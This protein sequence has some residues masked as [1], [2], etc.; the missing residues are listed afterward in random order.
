MYL[1]YIFVVFCVVFCCCFFVFFALF[2]GCV[3][4]TSC[5]LIFDA[6]YVFFLTSF[7]GPGRGHVAGPTHKGDTMAGSC[8]CMIRGFCGPA[9][10]AELCPARRS[11]RSPRSTKV[12]TQKNVFFCVLFMRSSFSFCLRKQKKYNAIIKM[13]RKTSNTKNKNTNKTIEKTVDAK[14][15]CISSSK[16]SF[17]SFAGVSGG[18]VSTRHVKHTRKSEERGLK[19]ACNKTAKKQQKTAKK[20][21]KHS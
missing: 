11:R 5:S 17:H 7:C 12:F 19:T 14:H 13:E 6:F 3:F 1:S 18:Y 10:F 2:F 16:E 20:M 15:K 21:Q 4:W 8:A 9:T